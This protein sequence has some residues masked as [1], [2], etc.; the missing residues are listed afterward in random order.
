MM[1]IDPSHLDLGEQYQLQDIIQIG[2]TLSLRDTGC[3]GD[4]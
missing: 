4:R 1:N 2:T 3:Y